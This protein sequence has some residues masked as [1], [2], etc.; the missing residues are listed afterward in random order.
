MLPE[1]WLAALRPTLR[2]VVHLSLFHHLVTPS[3][4][5]H[6]PLRR[7]DDDDDDSDEEACGSPAGSPQLRGDGILVGIEEGDVYSHKGLKDLK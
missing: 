5:L 4:L 6:D 3:M 2:G 1:M 7:C